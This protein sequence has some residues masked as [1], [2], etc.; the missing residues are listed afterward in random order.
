MFRATVL[1]VLIATPGDTVEEVAAIMQSLHTWNGRRAEA[2]GVILLPRHWKSDTVPLLNADGG[3]AVVNSQIVDDA[4][5][6]IA[7]FD[8]RLGS[9]TMGSVSGTA[10]E[11]ERSSEAGK[12]VHVYFSDEPIERKAIDLQELARLN[13]FRA[14]MEA[15]GLVGVY[16]NPNDLGYQ[17]RE[18]IE[19][20]VTQMDLGVAELP[21]AAP[22]EHAMPRLRWDEHNKRLVAENMSDAVR[23]DELML[24]IPNGHYEIDYDGKPVNLL[25]RGGMAQW[26]VVLFWQSPRQINVTVRW[27]ENGE[28]HEEPQT[29]YFH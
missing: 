24:D 7:V 25:P 18:A 28:P 2:E 13:D 17:V 19:H 23:A 16:V 10:H 12:P 8:R 20:D 14:E 3:Q 6:V 22:P 11:I 1:K 21:I 9:A 29:V 27:L 5:I 4:D 26:P 15:K